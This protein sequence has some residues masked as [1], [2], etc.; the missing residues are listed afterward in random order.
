[1]VSENLHR[2]ELNIKVLVDIRQTLLSLD[3]EFVKPTHSQTEFRILMTQLEVI[4]LHIR[5]HI[6]EIQIRVDSLTM[7]LASLSLGQLP[8]ELF[9]PKKLMEVLQGITKNIPSTWNL[10]ILAETNN[11][12]LLYQKTRVLTAVGLNQKTKEKGLK[13]FLHIPTNETTYQF[14]L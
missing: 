3:K 12:W 10:V 8:A 1:M 4:F 11:V 9:P 14:E 5:R 6:Q 7:G 13:L 2:T